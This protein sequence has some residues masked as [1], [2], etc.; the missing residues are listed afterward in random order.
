MTKVLS[1]LVGSLALVALGVGALSME[2]GQPENA[3]DLCSCFTRCPLFGCP[4][5]TECVCGGPCDCCECTTPFDAQMSS[6]SDLTT[7]KP[8]CE[9]GLDSSGVDDFGVTAEASAPR[10][11]KRCKGRPWCECTLD[12]ARRISCDPC[13]YDTQP[14]PTCLD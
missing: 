6:E 9:A 5:G 8:T 11:C 4:P 1:I 7:E 14:Y 10:G 12:G 2:G 13:C 3:A